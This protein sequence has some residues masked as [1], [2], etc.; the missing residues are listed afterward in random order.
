[1]RI[2]G[3]GGEGIVTLAELVAAAAM[4]TGKKVQTLPF[5]GV[6]RRGAPVK[7]LVRISDEDIWIHSQSYT[8]DILLI[9]NVKLLQTA[10]DQGIQPEGRIVVNTNHQNLTVD[11]PLKTIDA[12]DI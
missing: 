5:F 6:E 3:Y 4:K 9:L 1:M 12:T 2:H 11:Y 8:P 7:A 10:I